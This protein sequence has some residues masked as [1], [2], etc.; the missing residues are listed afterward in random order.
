MNPRI[1]PAGFPDYATLEEFQSSLKR[2]DRVWMAMSSDQVLEGRI[3]SCD[4]RPIFSSYFIEYTDEAGKQDAGSFDEA[5]VFPEERWAAWYLVLEK[6]RHHCVRNTVILHDETLL[7][8]TDQDP[9]DGLPQEGTPSYAAWV[10][11]ALRWHSSYG[12]P[13]N[14]TDDQYLEIPE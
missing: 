7:E 11:D 2:G 3:V 4:R 12:D 5:V 14:T 9:K 13:M 6:G 8:V 10:K 1:N